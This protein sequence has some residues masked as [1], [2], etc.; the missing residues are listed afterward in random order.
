[1]NQCFR[2]MGSKWSKEHEVVVSITHTQVHCKNVPVITWWTWLLTH[3]LSTGRAEM[4]G[5][6]GLPHGYYQ[7]PVQVTP[8]C[9]PYKQMSN[10]SYLTMCSHWRDDSRLVSISNLVPFCQILTFSTR[11]RGGHMTQFWPMIIEEAC[12][13]LREKLL[14]FLTK[15]N[16]FY[17][18]FLFLENKND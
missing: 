4:L 15:G 18:Y 6:L 11:D 12:W 3:S 16:L 7:L 14:C 17:F 5:V 13:K 9:L 10:F 8:H 2:R 1:M